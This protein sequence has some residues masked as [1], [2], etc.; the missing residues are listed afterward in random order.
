MGSINPK[1]RSRLRAAA[2]LG[3]AALAAAAVIT[4]FCW[5]GGAPRT[6]AA[7]PAPTA[8]PVSVV[9]AKRQDVPIYLSGL[10]SVQAA[11]TIAVHVQV[12]GVLQSV[13]FKEGQSVKKGQLLA[14]IDPRVYQAALEQAKAKKAQDQAQLVS[15]ETDLNRFVTL[16]S[17]NAETQQNVDHQR[18]LVAQIKA[19]ID[20]DQAAIDSAQV[21]VDFTSI[22][23]PVDGRVGIR[24][25][26]PGNVVHAADQTPLVTVTQVKPISVIFTLPATELDNVRDALRKGP[27][28]VTAFDQDNVK[29][30][31]TGTLLLIDNIIDQTTS[32]IRLKAVFANEDERF[33]PGEFVN[34][35]VHLETKTGVLAV[36]ETA[37]QRG[38]QGLTA[39]VVT[40]RQTAELRNIQAGPT[41]GGK[42]I[43]TAGLTEGDRV[44]TNGQYRLQRNV[45]VT[46][47]SPGAADERSAP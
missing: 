39:W 20:A 2:F 45:P 19:T 14:R 11:N 43:V 33:W 15:A 29:A 46:I 37:I 23:S 21:Q 4:F 40:P 36:P 26:D 38:P 24:Q 22:T 6:A 13:E 44:V 28:A 18:A 25:V 12:D 34:A 35:R 47:G 41:E 7:K 27:V 17:R 32:T 8:V 9:A 1:K 42:K 16:L 10:G 31:G 30:L 5:R 3:A